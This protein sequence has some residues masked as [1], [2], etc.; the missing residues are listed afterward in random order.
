MDLETPVCSDEISCIKLE[1]GVY[2]GIRYKK[3][4]GAENQCNVNPF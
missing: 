4:A 3:E 1:K 2:T